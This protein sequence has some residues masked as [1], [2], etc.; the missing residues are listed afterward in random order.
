MMKM[1][2]LTARNCCKMFTFALTL[3]IALLPGLLRPQVAAAQV[4]RRPAGRRHPI[5]TAPINHRGPVNPANNGG[6]TPTHPPTNPGGASKPVNVAGGGRIHQPIYPGPGYNGALPARGILAYRYN[7]NARL[8]PLTGAGWE[9]YFPYRSVYYPNYALGYTS[10]ATVLGLYYY[11]ATFPPYIGR[12]SVVV[13]PPQV[14]YI[15]VPLYTSNGLYQGD[16]GNDTNTY[17]LNRSQA[18][19]QDGNTDMASIAEQ[20]PLLDR[21]I[22][23][24]NTIWNTQDIHFLARHVRQGA[25]VAVY[26][27]GEYFYSLTGGDYLNMTRDA[28]YATRTVSFTLDKVQRKGP[29]IY[30]VS[31]RHIYTD[32]EGASHTV[33]VSYVL[34]KVEDDYYLSQVGTTPEKLE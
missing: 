15:P 10:G 11:Y 18:D 5:T 2:L 19:A 7:D 22:S 30:T 23:D 27:Q 9:I 20:D 33:L 28:L 1:T 13:Q 34:A 32:R 16:R 17:S 25:T 12:A 3:V 21:A 4:R 31:G 14:A 24:L 8:Y 26:L 29:T 6:N